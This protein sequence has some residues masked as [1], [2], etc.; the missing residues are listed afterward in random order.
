MYIFNSNNVNKISF[1]KKYNLILCFD[2][3]KETIFDLLKKN[4]CLITKKNNFSLLSK[5][6]ENVKI[7]KN[8]ILIC[9]NFRK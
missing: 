3:E 5:K 7:C 2:F 6:F 8:D 4:G 9:K 1:E